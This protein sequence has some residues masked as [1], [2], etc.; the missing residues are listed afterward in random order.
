MHVILGGTGHVGSAAAM[1][2]LRQGE[3]VTVVTRDE[4]KAAWLVEQGAEAAVADVL[5][6]EALREVLR[7]G[8]RAFLLNPPADPST[9]TDAEERK[10]VGA[11]A[12]ALEGSGL[13]KLVAESTYGAQAGEGVGDL[14]VLYGL[15][16]KLKAQAIPASIN[17]A[18]Y[19]MSNW[20]QALET[21]RRDGVITSFFPADFELPMVAPQ[22][23]GEAAARRLLEPADKTGT[24]Y[25]E[26]PRRYSAADVA[27][28]FSAALRKNVRVVTVPRE[29]WTETYEK[30][31]FSKAAAESYARMTGAT[32]DK[33]MQPENPER[34][35]TSL[36]S[37]IA[38]LVEG[39][40]EDLLKGAA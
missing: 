27:A 4:S 39:R 2:L 5:D 1:A 28:A 38:A 14:T 23:L 31:G 37:Y 11:I 20:D 22:D 33:P 6:V 10:T 30:L 34:G 9:D 17:R 24:H 18:A 8:K 16:Q 29:R 19:Y 35:T 26:G 36:E 40:P 12:A 21:A 15:E 25:I 13:E 32:L 7:R 3:D